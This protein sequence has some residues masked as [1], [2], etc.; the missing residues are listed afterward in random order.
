[1]QDDRLVLAEQVAVRDAEQQGVSDLTCGAGDGNA[2]WGLAIENLQDG[3][4]RW[5]LGKTPFYARYA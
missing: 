5:T 3:M 2:L 4:K 1:L